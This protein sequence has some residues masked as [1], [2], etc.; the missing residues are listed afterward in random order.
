MD[1]SKEIEIRFKNIDPLEK[2]ENK[3]VFCGSPNIIIRSSRTRKVPDMGTTFEEVIA[4]IKEPRLKCQACNGEF[5]IHHPF[6]PPKYEY[7]QAIIEFALTQFHYFNTSGKKISKILKKLAQVDVSED[8]IYTWLHK[9]SPE[10]L[11]AK[12]DE[13]PK[14]TMKEVKS[15]SID[16]S[17]ISMGKAAIGKKKLVDLLSVTKLK[18][19]D[20]LL[21]WW[22]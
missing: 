21:M 3:C 5:N 6:Y 14:K 4:I 22:E 17:H 10:F 9:L 15:I 8:T 2:F 13:S 11:K 12:L 18:N 20:Y 1:F 16:G 19:G 7:S